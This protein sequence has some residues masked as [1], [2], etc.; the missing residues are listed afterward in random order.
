[1]AWEITSITDCGPG[2]YYRFHVEGQNTEAAVAKPF[3]WSVRDVADARYVASPAASPE[4]QRAIA[5]A[6]A[7]G[8]AP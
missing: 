6:K 5:A 1:M 8:R 7:A 3:C 4:A 2:N